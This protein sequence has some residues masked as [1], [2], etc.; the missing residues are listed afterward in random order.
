M[1]S[2]EY[3]FQLLERED[4]EGSAELLELHWGRNSA[5]NADHLKWKYYDNPY[6]EEPI[7]YTVKHNGSVVG[8]M[9]LFPTRWRRGEYTFDCLSFGDAIIHPDHRGKGLYQPLIKS[10]M[11]EVRDSGYVGF[12]NLSNNDVTSHVMEKMG[13]LSMKER[14]YI[15]RINY[16]SFL[17]NFFFKDRY[18]EYSSGNV[19]FSLSPDIE[20][21]MRY[22]AK[23]K[24]DDRIH[25]VKDSDFYGWRYGSKRRQYHC[26]YN[27]H[28]GKMAAY[29]ILYLNRK[30]SARII[31]FAYDDLEYLLE[32]VGKMAKNRYPIVNI[33]DV[34]IGGDLETGL[35]KH[36][37]LRKHVFSSFM[38]E[39][40]IS[41]IS[42]KHIQGSGIS[43]MKDFDRTVLEDINN[44]DI[45]EIASDGV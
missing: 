15:K 35:R 39:K 6:T 33:L 3:E 9:G 22:D 24:G 28:D 30:G 18:G 21:M 44:W 26:F 1:R 42:Y 4:M 13:F 2:D 40:G 11:D 34:N 27:H 17:K 23:T 36:K 19:R 20:G 31:D 37:F 5:V 29:L 8:F 12:L 41:Y 7:A 10:L 25:L 43:E 38:G 45:K 14:S 32:I 16:F